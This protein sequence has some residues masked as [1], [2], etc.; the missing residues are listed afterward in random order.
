[1][2]PVPPTCSGAGGMFTARGGFRLIFP[3]FLRRICS[4]RINSLAAPC[5]D[6]RPR[7]LIRATPAA[8]D[9]VQPLRPRHGRAARRR[10]PR[11]HASAARARA[12]RAARGSR[13]RVSGA[14][15]PRGGAGAPRPPAPTGQVAAPM[16]EPPSA[17]ARCRSPAAIRG[18]AGAAPRAPTVRLR[19]SSSSL[20]IVTSS[21]PH[22]QDEHPPRGWAR[23]HR[24]S[25]AVE[26]RVQHQ[27]HLRFHLV[28]DLAGEAVASS[29]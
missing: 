27:P 20:S 21:P 10:R 6:E 4:G 28:V 2:S 8:S 9:A 15:R 25:V 13:L 23:R 3:R 17:A 29:R 11:W 24:G 5:S 12:R 19:V 7:D 16:P 14:A 1:M 22:I 18:P 26:D